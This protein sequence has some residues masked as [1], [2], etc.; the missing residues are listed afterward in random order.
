MGFGNLYDLV[1]SSVVTS[2][3]RARLCEKEHTESHIRK[4]M[5][6]FSYETIFE[7]NHKQKYYIFY[8]TL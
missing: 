1:I 7:C 6:E 8:S 4:F 5:P 2:K 3:Q